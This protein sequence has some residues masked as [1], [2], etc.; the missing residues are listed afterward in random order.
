MGLVPEL[1]TG[2]WVG[3]EDRS[4]HFRTITLG[5]GA[6]M[7]LPI[8]AIYMQKLFD[9][10]EINLGMGDFEPPLQGLSVEFDCD[11]YDALQQSDDPDRSDTIE[12]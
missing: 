2:I 1:T 7:A 12:F 5:Q 3:C 6:N 4:A 11:K 8:W 9:D 10:P